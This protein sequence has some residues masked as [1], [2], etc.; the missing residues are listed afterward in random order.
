MINYDKTQV[1]L[2]PS[3]QRG[4]KAKVQGVRQLKL[5]SHQERNSY[6]KLDKKHVE[7]K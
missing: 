5:K 6:L 4:R 2:K 7:R 1:A 3:R